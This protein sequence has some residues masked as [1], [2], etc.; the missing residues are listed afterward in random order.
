MGHPILNNQAD[1][2]PEGKHLTDTL[3]NFIRKYIIAKRL[4]Q[5][6]YY[7][8]YAP[9]FLILFPVYSCMTTSVQTVNSQ[10]FLIQK[11]SS[12]EYKILRNL[13]KKREI[14]IFQ[15]N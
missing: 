14:Q 3:I 12:E 7:I 2:I 10:D 1:G 5:L 8:I 6:I 11:D 13:F 15:G 4:Y 9:V